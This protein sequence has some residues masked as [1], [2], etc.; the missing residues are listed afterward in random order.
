MEFQKDF[1][2]YYYNLELHGSKDISLLIS[3]AE[4]KLSNK[5]WYEIEKL[6]KNEYFIHLLSNYD[7]DLYPKKGT[8]DSDV[9]NVKSLEID[10]DEALF[11][12]IYIH[13][14]FKDTDLL[15]N[16][17]GVISVL[18]SGKEIGNLV[19]VEFFKELFSIKD[20]VLMVSPI[21]YKNS[22]EYIKKA[23]R[24]TRLSFQV[25]SANLQR[26][27]WVKDEDWLNSIFK[28][29]DELWGD[30]VSFSIS[31]K[32]GLKKDSLWSFW[33]K[34][35][36]AFKGSTSIT[37]EEAWKQVQQKIDEI[38]FKS[39][40]WLTVKD[41]D[42]NVLEV[43]NSMITNFLLTIEKIREEYTSKK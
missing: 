16:S 37:V 40:V 17:V 20:R 18:K 42:L 33:R 29:K 30:T 35:G 3:S 36:S 19:L 5:Q 41:N 43:K 24:V 7:P 32:W 15:S 21:C 14:S 22:D 8:K 6:S 27:L 9:R 26:N 34:H 31:W 38:R 23:L 25:S 28:L 10:E 39:V 4:E 13:L 11:N 1:T 2:C 12:D